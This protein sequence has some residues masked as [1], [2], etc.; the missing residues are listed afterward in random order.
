MKNKLI[1]FVTVLITLFAFCSCEFLQGTLSSQQK[2]DQQELRGSVYIDG[3]IWYYTGSA[4]TDMTNDSSNNLKIC[5]TKSVM[6]SDESTSIIFNV[7]YTD[8]DNNEITQQIKLTG[9]D[10]YFLDGNKEFCVSMSKVL[11]LFDG[12]SIKDGSAN[13]T[14]HV[15]GFVN[16]EK[17]SS[18]YGRKLKDLKKTFVI[19]PLFDTTNII[20]N[21]IS[22]TINKNIIIDLNAPVE[23]SSQA[24]VSITSDALPEILQDAVF[25]VSLSDNKTQLLISS[26][27]DYSGN[28]FDMTVLV[29]G[30]I[31]PLSG[32]NT[33]ACFYVTCSNDNM[34]SI[35]DTEGDGLGGL[36]SAGGPW[37]QPNVD[38]K[39]LTLKQDET[40]LYV[41]L[42]FFSLT[43]FWDNDRIC[44][45]IDKASDESGFTNNT[46]MNSWAISADTVSI[47]NGQ[48]DI[49]L[50]HQPGGSN[51]ILYVDSVAIDEKWGSEPEKWSVSEYAWT[52]PNAPVSITYTIPLENIGLVSGDIISVIATTSCY[53]DDTNFHAI[54]VVPSATFNETNNVVYDFAEGLKLSIY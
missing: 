35:K 20:F 11:K 29:D 9:S 31:P 7:N 39:A 25:D 2:E 52:N 16:N 47:L 30:I 49:Y 26:D 48:A 38:I 19:E 4:S 54:D 40:N 41:T 34:I 37:A 23:L 22:S 43:N 18:E 51:S 50:Y 21:T 36:T 33:T 28:T 15:S 42:D 44:I 8:L 53:W 45:L 27:T 24:E 12:K 46:G 14:L 10:G 32:W 1:S 13:V 5:F 3:S 6:T 17:S